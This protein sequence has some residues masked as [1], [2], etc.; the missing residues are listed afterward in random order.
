[1]FSASTRDLRYE[2]GTRICKVMSSGR[3]FADFDDDDDDGEREEEMI[4]TRKGERLRYVLV[5]ERR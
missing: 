2:A 1:M 3:R 4:G 5:C